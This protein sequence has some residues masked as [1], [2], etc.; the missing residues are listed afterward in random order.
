M[1]LNALQEAVLDSA[2]AQ[3]GLATLVQVD[4]SAVTADLVG[5]VQV[6]LNDPHAA[7]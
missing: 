1:L 5:L 4:D 3:A 6:R 7:L 2:T